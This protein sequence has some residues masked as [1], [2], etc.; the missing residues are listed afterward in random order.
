MVSIKAASGKG[1]GGSCSTLQPSSKETSHHVMNGRA[2]SVKS[3]SS[4]VKPAFSFSF[5]SL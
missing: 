2:L 5:T 1:A 3:V 4:V